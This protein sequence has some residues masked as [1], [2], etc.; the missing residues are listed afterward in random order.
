[1]VQ[2]ASYADLTRAIREKVPACVEQQE[3]AQ[4][5]FGA[6][7]VRRRGG[8]YLVVLT[9]EQWSTYARESLALVPSAERNQTA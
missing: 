6:T 2:V 9:P 1:V 3:R 8:G 5:T 7:F 4:A